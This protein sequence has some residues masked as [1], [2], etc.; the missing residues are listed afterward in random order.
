MSRLVVVSGP[1]GSGKSTLIQKLLKE[2]PELTF[3]VSHTTRT[4]RHNEIDGKDYYFV[5]KDK[6][7]SMRQENRF[8][9]WA[10]V[11]QCLY[12]TSREEIED[13]THP[14]QVKILDIDV[15]G[16]ENI[17]KVFPRALYVFIV[18]PSFRE[19]EK[20]LQERESREERRDDEDIQIRL[21]IAR[22]E[23]MKYNQYDYV[24]VNDRLD[25]AYDRLRCI[26]RAF[27][28]TMEN[29]EHVVRDLLETKT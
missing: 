4:P 20:R 22:N 18:P 29:Q 17:R 25:D 11:H 13:G 7:L 27:L 3:A 23:I 28:N 24:I 1:S 21:R 26:Y 8:V 16:A 14:S 12:G 19:L 15:Q 6:F 9:E 10:E 5:S 2:F